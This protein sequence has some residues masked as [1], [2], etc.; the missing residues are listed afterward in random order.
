[1]GGLFGNQTVLDNRSELILFVTPRVVSSDADYDGVI[2][3]LRRKMES[4][5]RVFP[6]TPN[7]PASPPPAD[8]KMQKFLQPQNWELPPQTPPPAGN[9]SAQARPSAESPAAGK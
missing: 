4:L 5:D 3:D 9:P 7:W 2:E 8:E 1:L 6:G